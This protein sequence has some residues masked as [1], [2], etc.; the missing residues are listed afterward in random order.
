M[1]YRSFAAVYDDFMAGTDYA[2]WVDYI[3]EIFRRNGQKPGLV[4]ELG[5]GSGS[6]TVIF[7]Q[8]GYEMI[9]LDASAEMLSIAR[10]KDADILYINQDMRCFEL[11]GT[12]DAVISL[13]DS[14]NYI[15]M[16]DDH[17]AVYRLVNNYLNPGGLFIFDMN[18]AYKYAA[19]GDRTMMRKSRGNY[20]IWD[21]RW[22]K[23]QRVNEYRLT[24]FIKQGRLYERFRETHL[25]RAFGISAVTNMLADAGLEL[26]G[27]YGNKTFDAPGPKAGRVFFVARKGTRHGFWP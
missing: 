27:V 24:M 18:T 14:M 16:R 23:D 6:A 12:V 10:Q 26:A 15:L 1:I 13:C 20:L 21:N 22:Y 3:E 19:I 17:L 9:G 11:Y 2:G 8:R 5:C 7:K 4:L 25:Q